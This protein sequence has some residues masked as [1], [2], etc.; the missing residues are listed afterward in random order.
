MGTER[1]KQ[2]SSVKLTEREE[3][4]LDEISPDADESG[5]PSSGGF[6]L[7]PEGAGRRGRG[8]GRRAGA[9]ARDG[10]ADGADDR[11]NPRAVR[12]GQFPSVLDA[13]HGRGAHLL[14]GELCVSEANQDSQEGVVRA[15]VVRVDAPDA[16][17]QVVSAADRGLVA[18]FR[19]GW[20]DKV[21]V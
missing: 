11:L 16:L 12:S 5:R 3:I 8:K 7:I 20:N 15:L 19:D 13:K 18:L 17:Q 6:F 14:G 4:F 1:R 10:A 2:Q 9:R 21:S